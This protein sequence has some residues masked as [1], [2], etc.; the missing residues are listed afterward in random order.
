MYGFLH[1]FDYLL[2]NRERNKHQNF[3][4]VQLDSWQGGIQILLIK[5]LTDFSIVYFIAYLYD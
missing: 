5:K 4:N 2:L 1:K 3:L